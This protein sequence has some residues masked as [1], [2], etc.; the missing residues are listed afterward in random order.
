MQLI[1]A[2]LHTIAD[3]VKAG[4]LWA[5]GRLAL[6]ALILLGASAPLWLLEHDARVRREV[7]LRQVRRQAAEQI[8]EL[9][10]RAATAL[11]DAE[12]SAQRAQE[13]E[14]RR[15]RLERE[16]ADL[17]SAIADLKAQEHA[18]LQEVAA[19]PFPTLAARLRSQLA[20]DSIVTRHARLATR[21]SGFGVRDSGGGKSENRNSKTENR[22]PSESRQ[23][24]PSVSGQLPVQADD[25][26]RGQGAHNP[27]CPIQD[28]KSLS[29][30]S[31][32]R[33]FAL[34]GPSPDL[35]ISNPEVVLTERGAR[36][37]AAALIE[38]D[39]CREQSLAKDG[40]LTHCAEQAAASGAV[41]EEMTRS[42][43]GLKEAVRLKDELQSRSEA[44]H[45]AEL[46]AARGSRLKRF[47][48]ALE[49]VAAGVAVGVVAAQ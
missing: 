11:R 14:A 38:R 16:E 39:A 35:R 22:Q 2:L 44:A 41:I 29:A 46:K 19:L 13:L 40:L 48:R 47:G 10:A 42:L 34:R 18:R 3:T 4:L 33:S 31:R 5:R 26:A 21:D 9:R 49:Y 15:R 43:A 12:A 37:V 20:P 6:I 1:N 24:L 27:E 32:A 45:R 17:R 36:A 7:E 25:A 28:S 8:A 23:H 30:K